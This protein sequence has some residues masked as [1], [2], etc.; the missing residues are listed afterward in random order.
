MFPSKGDSGIRPR[1]EPQEWHI[2]LQS[3][4]NTT[5]LL[6]SQGAEAGELEKTPAAPLGSVHLVWGL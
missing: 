1:G 2:A 3:L 4:H 6:L 5:F